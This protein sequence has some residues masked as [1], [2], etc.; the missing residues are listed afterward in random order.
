VMVGNVPCVRHQWNGLRQLTLI[1]S[2]I[3]DYLEPAIN[4]QHCSAILD[5]WRTHLETEMDW[6]VCDWQDLSANTPLTGLNSSGKFELATNPDTPCSEIRLTGT[7]DEFRNARSKDLKRNLR[8]YRKK[9]EAVGS[10][11]FHV[12]KEAHSELMKALVELHTAKWQRRGEPGMIQANGSA[13]FLCEIARKFGSRDMLRFFSLRFDGRIVALIVA[14]S[15]GKTMFGYLS[16]FDPE[17]ESFGF[18][19]TLLLEALQYCYENG[20]EAWNFLRGDEP[21]KFWWGAQTVPKCRIRLVR[22]DL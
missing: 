9:A 15:Y 10:L 8:R 6:D 4:P 7:F 1:G 13:E 14:F 20:Y 3:S 17:H 19:R 11:Q 12:V 5:R 18:G 16:A 21:Y 2:G 22:A